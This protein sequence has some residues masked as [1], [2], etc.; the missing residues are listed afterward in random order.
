LL[1]STEKL[2]LEV[3]IA[4]DKKANE[5]VNLMA[6]EYD[7]DL[8]L[9]H[10]FEKLQSRHKELWKGSIADIWNY[11]FHGDACKFENKNT[12]QLLNIKINRRGNYGTI[13]NFY[14][15]KFM[16]TTQSLDY[17]YKKINNS[18]IMYETLNALT[19]KNYIIDANIFETETRVLNKDKTQNVTI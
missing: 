16:E 4:F 9:D 19:D 3:I 14:L 17:A 7:L 2:L 5:L 10:P 12:K 11:Q 6:S 18:K 15:L 1:N 13:S 8:S